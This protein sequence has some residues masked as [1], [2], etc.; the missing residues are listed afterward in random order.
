MTSDEYR[1]AVERDWR[2]NMAV[3]VAW[4]FI[5]AFGMPF[6]M[7]STFAPAYLGAVESPKWLIGFVLSCPALFGAGQIFL[8]HYVVP[9]R[10]LSVFRI[11]MTACAIPL[12]AYAAAATIW[13]GKWPPLLHWTLYSATQIIFSGVSSLVL[14]LY[15]EMMTDNVP[16][17]R[18]GLLFGLRMA[19]AGVPGLAM[20]YLATQFLARFDTPLNFRL[21]FLIGNGFFLASCVVLWFVRD[22]VNPAHSAASQ[23]S[24]G[25][26]FLHFAWD[27]LRTL[28]HE[29]N[30]RTAVI[31]IV[32]LAVAVN[33]APFMVA[34]AHEKL[35]ATAGQQGVFGVIY[36][37]TMAGLGWMIGLIADRRGY[38]LVACLCSALMAVSLLLCLAVPKIGF[39]YLA[40]GAYSLSGMSVGMILCNLG[41]EQC[42]G[43]PPNRLM[44][45]GNIIVM[46]F[47]MPATTLGGAAADICGGYAPV[48][49]VNLALALAALFGFA[50]LMDD[51]RRRKARS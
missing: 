20:G 44:A 18:R 14:S 16:P 11:S 36:L 6:A 7:I 43:V 32:L 25:K 49:A 26:A 40:Y 51:P 5:W 28:W 2:H 15:W 48:F 31:F 19:A 27:S 21:G 17:L 9:Q 23:E 10:R 24:G 12:L 39:W 22:N 45:V 38:R 41:A 13:G 42:P 1:L 4:E 33:S 34:A 37:G 47:V 50:F 30:F 35:G 46:I 29:K 3:F 8:S